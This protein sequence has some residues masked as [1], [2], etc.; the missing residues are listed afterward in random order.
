MQ[1]TRPR[2]RGGP[3]A[4]GRDTH[5]WRLSLAP[6][7]PP[8]LLS[9]EKRKLQVRSEVFNSFHALQL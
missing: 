4:A 9:S 7:L 5:R 8:F 6:S 1:L 3:G 2:L